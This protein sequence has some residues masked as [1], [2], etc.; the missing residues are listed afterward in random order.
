MILYVKIRAMREKAEC[1]GIK[2]PNQKVWSQ[3]YL[4]NVCYM[5]KL[6]DSYDTFPKEVENSARL[7]PITIVHRA[8]PYLALRVF[9]MTQAPAT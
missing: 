3:S 9:T 5:T 4:L 1:K 2:S 7:L 8:F 6:Y